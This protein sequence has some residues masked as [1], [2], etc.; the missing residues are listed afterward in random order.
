MGCCLSK[1]QLQR[2]GLPEKV[3]QESVM[4][5]LVSQQNH[6]H[7]PLYAPPSY[8]TNIGNIDARLG[9]SIDPGY[10]YRENIEFMGLKYP[11]ESAHKKKGFTENRDTKYVKCTVLDLPDD[12]ILEKPISLICPYFDCQYAI[13]HINTDYFTTVDKNTLAIK[14]AV[15]LESTHLASKSLVVLNAACDSWASVAAGRQLYYAAY[16]VST[17][18]TA[19]VDT[20]GR[21]VTHKV[22]SCCMIWNAD[23]KM[24]VK[25]TSVVR[26]VMDVRNDGSIVILTDEGLAHYH[27]AAIK[28]SPGNTI[29]PRSA[30][31]L[32]EASHCIQAFSWHAT[33]EA[34]VYAVLTDKGMI[35]YARHSLSVKSFKL[36]HTARL[37]EGL[38]SKAVSSCVAWIWR[39]AVV[40][41]VVVVA[42]FDAD[43]HANMVIV[44]NEKGDRVA[45]LNDVAND[46][47][48]PIV[49]IFG[50]HDDNLDITFVISHSL[51]SVYVHCLNVKHQMTQIFDR[52]MACV[53]VNGVMTN[54]ACY[55]YY[56]RM[57]V[58]GRCGTRGAIVDMK[59]DW[60]A[61]EI[62]K[63]K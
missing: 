61:D 21:L 26:R 14:N 5:A 55:G 13:F 50:Y 45:K 58:Y 57:T 37:H 6:N 46:D 44:L 29:K 30:I 8:N 41:R 16:D 48:M 53:D 62:R 43:R 36:L 33:D 52:L 28:I 25:Q 39:A 32:V 17:G 42:G 23:A 38:T 3:I 56:S 35:K 54:L 2:N 47:R 18:K 59:L 24:F 34:F 7:Y 15:Q 40:A 20:G 19:V 4:P 60:N 51:T 1:N 63:L 22:K 12:L 27:I 31:A 49:G 10:K 11:D 9:G